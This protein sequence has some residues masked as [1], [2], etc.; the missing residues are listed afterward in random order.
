MAL[1]QKGDMTNAKAECQLALANRPS[2]AL[3]SQIRT[4]QASLK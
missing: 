4:L 3:E 2:K 1:N